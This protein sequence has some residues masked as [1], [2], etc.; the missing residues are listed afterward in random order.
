[1]EPCG[2]RLDGRRTCDYSGI[3]WGERQRCW[4]HWTVESGR[5]VADVSDGGGGP[6]VAADSLIGAD[7]ER[8]SEWVLQ[9][10]ARQQ[11][12]WLVELQPREL[13]RWAEPHW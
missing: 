2:F 5:P 12:R 10:L 8:V 4:W 6:W 13:E 9:R 7:G 11:V 3:S 1:M